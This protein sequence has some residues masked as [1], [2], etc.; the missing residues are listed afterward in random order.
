MLDTVSLS[1]AFLVY[2]GLIAAIVAGMLQRTF[3]GGGGALALAFFA[4]WLAYAGAFSWLGL[5]GDPNMRPPGVALLVG[6]VF[7]ALILIVGVLP[8]GQR[9]AATLPVALLIGFQVFRVGVELTITEL[10]HQGLAPQLLTLPGGNVELLV[11]LSAPIF[12]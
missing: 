6:P 8:A 11:A 2:V 4:L 1:T 12:A 9:L 10:H 5:L 7:A 3:R